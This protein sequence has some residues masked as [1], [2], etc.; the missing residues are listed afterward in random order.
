MWPSVKPS[1]QMS[2][3]HFA[4]EQCVGAAGAVSTTYGLLMLVWRSMATTWSGAQQ[5]GQQPPPQMS[6]MVTPRALGQLIWGHLS[7]SALPL[8]W[9]AQP[10]G[11]VYDSA[12]HGPTNSEPAGCS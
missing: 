7:A 11:W 5:V 9:A 6:F 4:P 8:N 2:L 10:S 3:K 1:A 12:G